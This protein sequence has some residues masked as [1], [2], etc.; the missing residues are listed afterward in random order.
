MLT[1]A[2]LPFQVFLHRLNQY[3]ATKID[4]NITEET[5]KVRVR[6]RGMRLH[7]LELEKYQGQLTFTLMLRTNLIFIK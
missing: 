6:L 2:F 1:A 4:K 5:V 3:A 7:I